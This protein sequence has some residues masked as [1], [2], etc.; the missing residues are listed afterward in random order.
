[1]RFAG[2]LKFAIRVR[3]VL[4]YSLQKF[5]LVAVGRPFEENSRHWNCRSAVPQNFIRMA[6]Q[7][8]SLCKPFALENDPDATYFF[9]LEKD[10]V[11]LESYSTPVPTHDIWK[12]F[13][14]LPTPPRSPSRSPRNSPVDFD[15]CSVADTLQIVSDILDEDSCATAPLATVEISL[16][17]LKSKLIQD[18]MW[19]GSNYEKSLEFKVLATTL[20]TEDL[21]ET[22]CSTPPPVEYVSSDCV[23]PSTVFPYPV[24]ESHQTLCASHTSSDSEEEID[25]VTIEKPKRKR[26]P[27]VT[28]EPPAKRIKPV[29][30]KPKAIMSSS[31]PTK[32]SK[33]DLKRQVSTTS[34]DDG[35][36]SKRATHNVLE[37]K[38]RNDLKTSFHV[39]REE[40]PELKDNERAPKVTILRKAKDC[41]DKLK[42]DETRLLAELAKE[43]QR[44]EELLDRFYA[45]GQKRK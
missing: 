31:S 21:Y 39:L 22:P 35:E 18:C 19:N 28:D 38:R 33:K 40:V 8:E 5:G 11:E 1:M 25:V 32:E 2:E 36:T 30:V 12:K 6:V 41:V 26:L 16:S 29:A 13:E 14:L 17:S 9:H 10:E 27:Q 43:R 44:N 23:D 15:C 37:R 20:N 3:P 34:D 45:L 7:V 4:F 24:N 42:K